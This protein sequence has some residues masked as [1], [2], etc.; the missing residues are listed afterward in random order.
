M[1]TSVP[2]T[3]LAVDELS[4]NEEV[5]LRSHKI[6]VVVDFWASWCGPCRQLGPVLESAVEELAGQVLLRT[7]DVD[8]NPGLA[9]TYSVRGIPAVKAFRAGAVSAEFVGA[10]PVPAVRAFLQGL[11]PS[12]ADELVERGDAASLRQALEMDPSHLAARRALARALI[13]DGEWAEAGR[14]AMQAPQDRLCDGLAA[15]AELGQERDQSS[16]SQDLLRQLEAGDFAAAVETAVSS[17][18]TVTGARRDLWRRLSLYCFEEL[19]PEHPA[20]LAG[21]SRLAAALY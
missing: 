18:A 9:R 5:I 17:V 20:A 7:L 16:G 10:Q 14:V 15:W 13:A 11:L 3:K 4:F 1:S 8:A 19:G 12:Q 6:P 2:A 21:R